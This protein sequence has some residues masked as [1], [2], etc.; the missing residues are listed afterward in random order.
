L[1]T[2]ASPGGCSY[3]VRFTGRTLTLGTAVHTGELFFIDDIGSYFAHSCDLRL[4]CVREMERMRGT[5]FYDPHFGGGAYLDT[6][7]QHLAR[8]HGVR[9]ER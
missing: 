5:E 8:W 7:G 9:R 6:Y 3:A 4:L 1:L 2:A